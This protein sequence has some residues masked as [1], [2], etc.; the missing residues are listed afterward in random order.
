LNEESRIASTSKV[1]PENQKLIDGK[2]DIDKLLN[3]IL[4]EDE[5]D[6]KL[7]RDYDSQPDNIYRLPAEKSEQDEPVLNKPASEANFPLNTTSSFS[8]ISIE[9]QTQITESNQEENIDE[10][11][12]E[13]I[14][15]DKDSVNT[16]SSLGNISI[17]EY[18]QVTDTNQEENIDEL[19][20]EI[21]HKDTESSLDNIS[22]EEQSQEENID[23]LINE[24]LE[25][26][27][28]TNISVNNKLKEEEEIPVAADKTR[29]SRITRKVTTIPESSKVTTTSYKQDKKESSYTFII[30][31]VLLILS[32]IGAWKFFF[33]NKESIQENI[34][35]K[36]QLTEITPSIEE[37]SP[38]SEEIPEEKYTPPTIKKY[39]TE[40]EYI[41][42]EIEQSMNLSEPDYSARIE[43]DKNDITITLNTPET[44]IQTDVNST[45]YNE[46]GVVGSE[47]LADYNITTTEKIIETTPPGETL[48]KNEQVAKDK[49]VVKKANK[50]KPTKAKA[51]ANRRVIIHRIVKGDTLWAIA[52]RYVHNPYRYPELAKLSK[53]KNPDRIYPGNKVRIIIYIK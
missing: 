22:V 33:N 5:L 3:E 48:R 7:T 4:H 29:T 36:E 44:A 47:P 1:R 20:N 24:I 51:K 23:E 8:N 19:I 12:Y 21:I 30:I 25:N 6:E 31:L 53:I 41:L 43:K 15:K 40:P 35:I 26:K 13:I 16:E 2:Q 14:H 37:D 46:N 18:T 32:F 9:E 52:K 17:E 45:I 39:K 34:I 10:L 50:E 27:T 11:I 28:D 49:A 38:F 42:S